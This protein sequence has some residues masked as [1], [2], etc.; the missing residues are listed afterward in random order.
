MP[1]ASFSAFILALAMLLPSA[2]SAVEYGGIGGRPANPIPG[3]ERTT[4]IFVHEIAGGS[5]DGDGIRVINNTDKPKTLMVDAVDSSASSGGAFA[6]AQ[7]VEPKADVGSWIVLDKTEVTLE[8]MTNEVIPFSISVPPLADV[9]EH[10]GCIVIQEKNA[11][12]QKQGGGIQLSF[13]T[14]IRV[15]VL[16]PGEMVRRLAIV[17]SDVAPRD[18][19]GFRLGAHVRNEGNVSVDTDVK[20]DVQD[21]MGYEK[22]S[23]GG[24]Y[25]ILRG[26]TSDYSFDMPQP[27]WG[28]WY[29]SRLTVTY[30][31]STDAR[32]GADTASARVTITAPEVT[33]YSY[34]APEA[35]VIELAVILAF[36]LGIAWIITN[37]VRRMRVRKTWV[38]Y[39]VAAGDD[40]NALAAKHRVS[41]KL[42]ASVNKLKPPY[43]LK[44]GDA[45]K[46]PPPPVKK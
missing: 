24:A 30:D 42:I 12:P 5:S 34:P 23:Y 40:V 39:A 35:A 18:G 37:A 17:G 33:F 13:R 11:E 36:L 10:N 6:C 44:P 27:K 26:Q 43:T 20:I 3:N 29:R 32:I 21:V 31:A 46:V 28:G 2:A 1:R 16:V 9:G 38:T 41:W 45:L 14:G 25:P 22:S 8:P 7:R 4:S 15:A 19:G